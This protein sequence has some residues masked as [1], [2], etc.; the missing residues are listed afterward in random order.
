LAWLFISRVG[1]STLDQWNVTCVL[2]PA[3]RNT[4]QSVKGSNIAKHAWTFGH[5]IDFDNP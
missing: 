4:N 5:V 2:D 3:I 1:I